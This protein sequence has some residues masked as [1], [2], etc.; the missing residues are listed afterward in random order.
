[1]N[2]RLRSPSSHQHRLTNDEDDHQVE[3]DASDGNG[4]AKWMSVMVDRRLNVGAIPIVSN[5]AWAFGHLWFFSC[6][7]VV[8]EKVAE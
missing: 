6:S 8:V 7:V 4:S 3:D 5:I 2:L 1:M